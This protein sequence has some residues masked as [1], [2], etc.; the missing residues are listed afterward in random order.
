MHVSP[1]PQP[2]QSCADRVGALLLA[3][4]AGSRLGH[5][6]KSALMLDG[7]PLI[8]RHVM[9]LLGAGLQDVV[10]VLGHH[11]ADL[12]PLIQDFPV[13]RV[14]NPD[15]DAGQVSSLRWGLQAFLSPVDAVLVSL[16]DLALIDSQDI[17]DVLHAY[18][19]RPV[20]TEVVVPTVQGL[21]GN[22]VV[23]SQA[24]RQSLL[25]Q[26]EHVGCK[27]WQAQHP[28]AVHHWITHNQN[29]RT[30]MDTPQD[31]DML[32]RTTGQRLQWPTT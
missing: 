3:A 8:R 26:A 25:A 2:P 5:R 1:E 4:G 29:Y 13:T 17:R 12:E 16:A 10:V 9:A 21:P 28:V 6:P 14:Y 22:P 23:F 11:A 24:V 27:D 7:V 31:I 19:E 18:A 15:P 30:D 20:H 32:A